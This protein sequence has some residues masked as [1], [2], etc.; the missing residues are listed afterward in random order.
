MAFVSVAIVE[1]RDR[2]TEDKPIPSSDA[3]SI[4]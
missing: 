2:E 4:R 3:R 1:G